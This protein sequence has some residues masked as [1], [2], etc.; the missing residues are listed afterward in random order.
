MAYYFT[1]DTVLKFMASLTNLPTKEIYEFKVKVIAG[2]C[3]NKI[4][5]SRFMELLQIAAPRI[6]LDIG[7]VDIVSLKGDSKPFTEQ[8]ITQILALGHH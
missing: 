7:G 6:D 2:K 8:E 5:M 1:E 3:L 4:G